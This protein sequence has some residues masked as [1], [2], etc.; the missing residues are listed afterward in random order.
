MNGPALRAR[1]T[2][3]VAAGDRPLMVV[4]TA[5]TVAT[6]AVDP[7][8]ELAAVAREHGAWF[9]VDGAYGAPAAAMPDPLEELRSPAG[10]ARP[11]CGWASARRGAR[12]TPG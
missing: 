9:H 3:D 7:L 1:L 5:G 4:G 6:G 2:S 11:R 12:D 10:S 8:R